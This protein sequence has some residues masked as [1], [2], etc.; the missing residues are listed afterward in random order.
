MIAEPVTMLTDYA[1][2]GVTASLAF[3]LYRRREGRRARSLWTLALAALALA[4]LLGGTSHGFAPTLSPLAAT[5]LWKATVLSVGVASFG[6]LAGSAAG[7]AS[8]PVARIFLV[9]AA[10]KLAIY[11]AWMLFHDEYLYVIVD[12]GTA[13]A[14]IAMLHLWSVATKRDIASAW[15]L[16]GVAISLLAAAV[17]ASGF[18]LHRNFNHNDLYHL[19]Q[20]AAMFLFHAGARRL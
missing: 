6:L 5:L 11:S 8:V 13:L 1:L 14:G 4:A 15:M 16:A 9:L 2:A 7:T 10:A 18:A 12:T 19:I 20:I 17:Q 3:S